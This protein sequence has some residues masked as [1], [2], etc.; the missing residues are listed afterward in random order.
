VR[1]SCSSFW[2]ESPVAQSAGLQPCVKPIAAERGLKG[3]PRGHSS[4]THRCSYSTTCFLRNIWNSSSRGMT[5]SVNSSL[6][7]RA[8]VPASRRPA[9]RGGIPK[10]PLLGN[11]SPACLFCSLGRSARRDARPTVCDT[12]AVTIVLAVERLWYPRTGENS[13]FVSDLSGRQDWMPGG[14]RP[15]GLRYVR[16]GFQPENAHR[17]QTHPSQWSV[18]NLV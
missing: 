7:V 6:S 9:K 11:D 10:L 17:L 15:E 18:L 2:A 8:S 4:Q 13:M 5:V 14:L 12:I 16:P 3:R 1:G